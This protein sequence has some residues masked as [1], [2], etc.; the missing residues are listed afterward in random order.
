MINSDKLKTDV[1]AFRSTK[2]ISMDVACK[3]IGISKPTFSRIER[4]VSFPDSGTLLKLCKW[5]DVN[6]MIYMS[7]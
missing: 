1:A 3:E 2:N 4:G 5:L 7:N 6:P